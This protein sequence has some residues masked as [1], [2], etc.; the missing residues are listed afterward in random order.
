MLV[1]KLKVAMM[2]KLEMDLVPWMSEVLINMSKM[3]LR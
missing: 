2:E 1:V 3:E